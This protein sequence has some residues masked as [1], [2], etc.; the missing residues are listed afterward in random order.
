MIIVMGLPGSGKS[1]VLS[2]AQ[3]KG[4]KVLN[5]GTLMM[6]I[7]STEFGVKDRDSLRTLP[8]DKQKRVQAKVGHMLSNER[9]RKVI[10]DTH[11]SINT[12]KGYLPGLPFSFL[13]ALYVERLVLLTAPAEDILKRRKTDK[14]RVRDAQSKASIIEHDEM[15]RI[16]LGAYSVITGA[17]SIIITNPN[18][19][20]DEVRQKFAS[21]LE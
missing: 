6:D 9:E 17:P 20:I 12:P 15:N 10:L 5:Y 11:C 19:K 4:W 18:G 1:T 13:G 3:E 21:L 8:A 7:A 14:T 2:V 16:Y